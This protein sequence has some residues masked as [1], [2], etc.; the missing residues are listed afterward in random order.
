MA[1]VQIANETTL[2][3]LAANFGL[4]R[5]LDPNFFREWQGELPELSELD[6]VVIAWVVRYY[7]ALVDRGSVSQILRC[8]QGAIAQ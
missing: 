2:V 5:S 6:R 7:E 1:V 3:A 4:Q 8:L